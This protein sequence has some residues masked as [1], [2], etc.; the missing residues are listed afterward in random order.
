MNVYVD[1]TVLLRIALGEPD[2]LSGWSGIANPTSSEIIRI[3]TL[4][5]ID[6]ARIGQRL[7]DAEVSRLRADLIRTMDSFALI[8]LSDVVKARASEPFP[9]LVGTLDAI[10]LSSALLAREQMEDLTFATHD[11]ELEMAARSLGFDVLT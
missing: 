1:S 6:R 5:T 8:T 9:T 11:R 3:E 4:R 2:A 10:H 7:D